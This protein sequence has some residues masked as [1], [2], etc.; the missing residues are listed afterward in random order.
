MMDCIKLL[1]RVFLTLVLSILSIP[2][3]FAF[4]ISN[5]LDRGFTMIGDF[6]Y[7][8]AFD[9]PIVQIGFIRIMLFV[10]MFAVMYSAFKSAG[11]KLKWMDNK[12]AKI[13]SFVFA[14]LGVFLMPE[15]WLMA[16]G[17]SITALVSAMF[18]LLI[19]GGGGYIAVRS[20]RGNLIANLM[21]I[22][23]ILALIAFVEV[24]ANFVGL[25]MF[26]FVPKDFFKRWTK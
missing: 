19:I 7:I 8:S 14:M 17:G 1:K 23:L 15:S 20:L 12:T 22:V 13:V 4:D 2:F 26:L 16:T 11:E 9:N 25:G 18:Y 5:T 6:F 24:W 21:G 3:A 10:A